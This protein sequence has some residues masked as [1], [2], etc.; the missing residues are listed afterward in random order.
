MRR[1]MHTQ[2]TQQA[3]D[4]P[5]LRVL[6]QHMLDLGKQ[7]YMLREHNGS[8]LQQRQLLAY[9]LHIT[10]YVR[11]VYCFGQMTK[12]ACIPPHYF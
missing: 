11:N 12:L 5:S 10:K 1:I 7:H 3:K 6:E 8:H 4:H 9:H 2:K